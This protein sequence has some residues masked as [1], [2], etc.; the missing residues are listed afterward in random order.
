[1]YT[2]GKMETLKI[3]QPDDWHIH[4]REGIYLQ[5][6]VS[7]AAAQFHR[8]LVMPNLETPVTSIEQARR[9]RAA[10]LSEASGQNFEPYMTL[11]LNES[12]KPETIQQVA[13]EDFILAIKLYPAGATTLSEQGVRN[14]QAI[15]PQLAA[16]EKAGLVLCVHGEVTNPE[17]DIF[18]RE[19]VFIEQVLLP[20]I[21]DFPDLKIVLEHIT[22]KTAVD[23]ILS[24][25]DKLAATITA[26]H[27]WI[28]RND[29]L[30]GGIKP[31]Y[32]CLPIVK[33][34]Q[35]QQSLIKAATSGNPKFFPNF[36]IGTTN[37][38]ASKCVTHGESGLCELR[39]L[40]ILSLISSLKHTFIC[41]SPD[42]SFTTP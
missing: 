42:L 10:I 7:D 22:T 25:S 16:L 8:A 21:N 27:L 15:Y 41:A 35:D 5:R 19:A 38:I 37:A 31:H 26:H 4:L 13:A 32:Y 3:Q 6:T 2:W 36:L 11:Y 29:L 20:I 12:L 14:I 24:T 9:Y 39:E 17:V 1:M 18:D 28:N 33:T 23:F 30:V 34:Q 40:S